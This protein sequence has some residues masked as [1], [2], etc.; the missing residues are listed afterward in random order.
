MYSNRAAFGIVL[1][2]SAG[3]LSRA[4]VRRRA[5]CPRT[6]QRQPMELIGNLPPCGSELQAPGIEIREASEDEGGLVRMQL[7]EFEAH[8]VPTA[9]REGGEGQDRLGAEGRGG[10]QPTLLTDED[11]VVN[12]H[13]LDILSYRIHDRRQYRQFLA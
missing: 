7:P 13:V 9:V 1:A 6:G 5:R 11:G 10:L 4:S 3:I 8:D 2:R 12:V